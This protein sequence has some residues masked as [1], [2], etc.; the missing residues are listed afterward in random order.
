MQILLARY[1]LVSF[2]PWIDNYQR[3]LRQYGFSCFLKRIVSSQLMLFKLT[4]CRVVHVS[5]LSFT[6][7]NASFGQNELTTVHAQQRMSPN[8][9]GDIFDNFD[10][11]NNPPTA[12]A[13]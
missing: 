6:V 4:P 9:T 5:L 12:W 3:P 1:Q 8:E 11:I 2:S 7:E 10:R 13:C